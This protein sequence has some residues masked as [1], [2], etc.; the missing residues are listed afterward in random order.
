[1]SSPALKLK[2]LAMP[3]VCLFSL[4]QMED[5]HYPSVRVQVTLLRSQKDLQEGGRLWRACCV[6]LHESLHSWSME[7]SCSAGHYLEILSLERILHG[8]I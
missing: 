5:G 7:G 1:M 3:H 6:H 8:I 2:G 4:G